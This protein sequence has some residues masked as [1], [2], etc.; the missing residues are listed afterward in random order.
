VCLVIGLFFQCAVF[1][2]S[3]GLCYICVLCRI[4]VG[5]I[6]SF[7]YL[8]LWPGYILISDFKCASFLYDVF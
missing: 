1:L 6:L 4:C 5:R 3:D 2:M 8:F 7:V